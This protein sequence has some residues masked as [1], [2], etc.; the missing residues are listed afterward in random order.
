M[1]L[2]EGLSD[3]SL[4]RLLAGSTVSWFD[5]GAVLF[6]Q[7]ESADRFY[8][9]LE[10]WVKLYRLT[11]NG[12]QA[13]MTVVAPGETFAEA[14]VF[15]NAQFPVC[16]EVVEGASVLVLGRRDLTAALA[17]DPQIALAMLASLSLRL[18]HLVGRIEQLQVR[19]APQRLGAF[20]LQ[21][22]VEATG[23]ARVELPFSKALLAQR[24]GMRP[25]TLSRSLATLRAQGVERSGGSITIEDIHRLRDFCERS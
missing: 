4:D 2:F 25:E 19:S 16:A 10:G 5:D 8:V 7:G 21:L 13:L 12:D 24:L 14:A 17:T 1:P 23:S 6:L 22:C 3:Q 15:A 9:L 20:L 11:E 18:R